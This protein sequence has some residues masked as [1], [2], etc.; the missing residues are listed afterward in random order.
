[1]ETLAVQHSQ[2][3]VDQGMQ[4]S[5]DPGNKMLAQRTSKHKSCDTDH[6]IG[7]NLKA[8][9]IKVLLLQWRK[10]TLFHSI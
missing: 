10:A 6:R 1:M 5:Q 8:E 2:A 4:L 7:C 3:N 9:Q